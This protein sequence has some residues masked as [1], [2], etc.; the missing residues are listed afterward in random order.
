M[1]NRS[2]S[3]TVAAVCDTYTCTQQTNECCL[4]AALAA[5]E[6][7]EL[8][9]TQPGILEKPVSLKRDLPRDHGKACNSCYSLTLDN[10]HER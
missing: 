10:S 2:S 1:N 7:N 6:L 3:G 4:A 5:E 8:A 9:L